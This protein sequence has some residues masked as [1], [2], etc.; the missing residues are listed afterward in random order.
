MTAGQAVTGASLHERRQWVHHRAL[1]RALVVAVPLMILLV[2]G[3]VLYISQYEPLG[4]GSGVRGIDQ[5]PVRHISL[6]TRT[7]Y[8]LDHEAG[9]TLRASFGVHNVG[10]LAVTVTSVVPDDSR[11]PEDYPMTA[12]R[13]F[14]APNNNPVERFRPVDEGARIEPGESVQF[15]VE[16][17]FG[18]CRYYD[19]GSFETHSQVPISYSVFGIEKTTQLDLG[20]DLVLKS[21]GDGQC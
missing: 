2:P 5:E 12:I 7:I 11:E 8:V 6:G 1:R 19:K 10:P 17:V 13:G 15:Q 4:P 20:Y 9:K 16:Y 3:G 14:Y 21:R 18:S